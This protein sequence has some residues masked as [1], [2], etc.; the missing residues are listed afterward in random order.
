MILSSKLYFDLHVVVER[1][2]KKDVF[3]LEKISVYHYIPER[4]C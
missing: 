4:L 1:F 2:L 3:L